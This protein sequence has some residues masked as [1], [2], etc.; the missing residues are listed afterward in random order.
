MTP[1]T[2]IQKT[3]GNLGVSTDTER[4]L[5]IVAPAAAGAFDTPTLFATSNDLTD[6]HTA[7]PLVVAVGH[8]LEQGIPCVGIRSNPTTAA[9]YGSIDSSGKAGTSAVTAGASAPD[10]TYDAIVEILT[11]GTRGA[12]GIIYRYSLDNGVNWSPDQALGTATTLT[13]AN[14]VSFALGAGT[15]V[16]GDTWECATTA[17]KNLSSDITDSLTALK[18]AYPGEWLR[19]LVYAD[20]DATT[21]A[22]CETWAKSHWADG[23][24]P[25][26]IMCTRPRGATEVRSDYVIALAAIA[27][28]VQTT[29]TSVCADQCE[30]VSGLDGRR[31]RVP[32]SLPFAA[33]SMVID[34][35]QDA[36]EYSVGALASTFLK[37]AD[38]ETKYH[39]ER[40]FPG[41]DVLGFTTLMTFGGT[42]V[43]P[44]VYVN[45]PRLLGGPGSDYRY[46]QHT[47]IL[48]RIIEKAHKLCRPKLSKSVLVDTSTGRIR[49]DVARSVEKAVTKDL[50][51]AFVDCSPP[52]VSGL[53]FV[54]SRT[55]D[56]LT[57]DTIHFSIAEVPLAV[58]K[59]MKG[60]AGLVRVLP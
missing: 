5:A 26:V 35:S 60:T 24:Y 15:L 50:R 38:G 39:D 1:S 43:T 40:K 10:N 4:I 2:D 37:T 22:L 9:A 25:E 31:L 56:I 42:P 16:T 14:G 47:A 3:N 29:E 45:N 48:N 49:E 59:K 46:F 13:C 36:G 27:A 54:L 52:R 44:G 6:A 23:K 21:I 30:I 32:T 55:D 8:C 7:G 34:D 19:V 58:I 41:L 28:A 17:P 20:A 51:T 11:G 12:A 18:D 57:T 33:R 53:A